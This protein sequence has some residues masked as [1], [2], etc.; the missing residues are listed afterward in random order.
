MTTEQ[1][2]SVAVRTIKK[3]SAAEKAELR[4]ALEQAFPRRVLCDGRP[5]A[6][7][8]SRVSLPTF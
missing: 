8:T 4:K 6:R 2:L 5:R 1:L 3:M 7:I